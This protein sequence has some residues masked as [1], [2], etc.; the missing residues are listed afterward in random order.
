MTRR[1]AVAGLVLMLGTSVSA[2]SGLDAFAR[3]HD[4]GG[5]QVKAIYASPEYFAAAG[6]ANDVRRFQLERQIVFL[7]SFDTHS[8]DLTP[9]DVVTNSRLVTSA[10]NTYEPVRWETTSDGS[11]HR[12]GALIFPKSANGIQVIGTGITSVSLVITN[13]AGVPSRSLTWPVP[14]R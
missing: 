8:V 7:L 13:L 5:V 9:F 1:L 11:R 12:S 4:S 10:G 3:T 14:V 6:D 2:A